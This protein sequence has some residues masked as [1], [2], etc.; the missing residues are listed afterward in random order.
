[1]EGRLLLHALRKAPDLPPLGQAEHVVEP[2][3]QGIVKLGV[4]APVETAHVLQGGGGVVKNV[5]GDVADG[6][7]DL[8]V[9][10]N[11]LTIHG[12][13]AA[14]GPVDAGQVPDGGGLARAVGADETVDRPLGHG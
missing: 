6:G 9:F 13:G 11:G 7:L 12:D 10:V 1:M 2:V 3:E 8:R 14:V 5:V 4:D